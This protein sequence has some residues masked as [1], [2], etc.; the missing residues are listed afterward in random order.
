MNAA[1][2]KAKLERLN[3]RA[4]AA[5]GQNFLCDDEAADKIA[6]AAADD[7]AWQVLEIGPGLGALTEK[8]LLYARSVTAVEIDSGMVRALDEEFAAPIESGNLT[9]V[10][11]DIL[12]FDFDS[13]EGQFIAA[14][15]LPYYIT[16]PIVL[17]LLRRAK[18]IP[19]MVLMVQKE[20]ARRFFARPKDSVYGPL[21]ITAQL[22]Y[23]CETLSSLTPASYYPQ[24]EVDSEVVLLKRRTDAPDI[25]PA[26]FCRFLENIFAMRRKTVYNN[27]K[28]I[29]PSAEAANAA[30][31][32][33]GIAPSA[34]AE[35]LSIA[36]LVRLY[37]EYARQAGS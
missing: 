23:N 4:N 29:M 30:L 33:A 31:E 37:T 15:N 7:G 21:A 8:L 26:L 11:S 1:D 3:M 14:G 5:L 13:L 35:A 10:H 6:R 18:R 19:R 32:R 12:K 22:F 28:S 36:E 24:P 27:L 34:R 25:D 17:S 20:A 2:I 9:I 16:T